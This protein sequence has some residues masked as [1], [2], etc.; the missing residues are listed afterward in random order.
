M[1][2]GSITNSHLALRVSVLVTFD[3]GI[4]LETTVCFLCPNVLRL[5][6][7]NWQVHGP[8]TESQIQQLRG[9]PGGAVVKNRLPMQGTRVRALVREDPTCHRAAKP[10]SHNYWAC[11]LEPASHNY[12]AFEPQL[13]SPWATATEA[14]APRVHAPQQ[15]EPPQWESLRTATKSSPR[16]PQLE[17][18]RAQQQRPNTATNK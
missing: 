5:V 7:P 8:L 2:S 12:W 10:V 15:E 11:T 14:H 17:K 6:S 13:L 1:R 16:S 18:A 3:L 4:T 9:F